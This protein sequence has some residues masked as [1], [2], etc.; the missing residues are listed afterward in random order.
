MFPA[1]AN[2]PRLKTGRALFMKLC[3]A[4]C[5]IWMAAALGEEPRA[6][7]LGATA[8]EWKLEHWINSDPVELSKWRGKVVLV[9]WWTAPDCPY[10]RATAPALN[11]FYDSYHAKGLE[12]IGIYHHKKATPKP[13][14]TW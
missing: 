10:C 5:A 7:T 6:L 11:E 4:W 2:A 8:T 13:I 3:L 12:T 1:G 9:R 14:R